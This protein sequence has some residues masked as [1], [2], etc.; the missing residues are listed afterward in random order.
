MFHTKFVNAELLQAARKKKGLSQQQLAEAAGC[1]KRTVERAEDGEN[2]RPKVIAAIA[3]Q[4]DLPLEQ[5]ILERDDNDR[6]RELFEDYLR[7]ISDNFD[8]LRILEIRTISEGAMSQLPVPPINQLFVEP[9]LTSHSISPEETP[10][11]WRNVSSATEI[12]AKQVGLTVVL[13]DPGSGKSSLVAYITHQ[14]AQREPTAL[15]RAL[16]DR[17]PIPIVLREMRF[18]HSPPLTSDHSDTPQSYKHSSN[19]ESDSALQ[20]IPRLEW[21]Q[22]I[23]SFYEWCGSRP[24]GARRGSAEMLKEQIRDGRALIMLDGLDELP[25]QIRLEVRNAVWDLIDECP[26]VSIICTSRPLGYAEAPFEKPD[27]RLLSA[28]ESDDDFD[29]EPRSPRSRPTVWYLSHFDDN[30]I[31][32]FTENWYKTKGTF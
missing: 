21:E 20:K 12:L 18:P 10:R 31:R 4:L 23:D 24:G 16:Q 5:L 8:S 15:S 25:R 28:Q 14:L 17:I 13:G 22:L 19:K 27:N 6:L 1:S 2:L 30:Q 26:N 3:R 32:R 29:A 7:L 9:F 11:H